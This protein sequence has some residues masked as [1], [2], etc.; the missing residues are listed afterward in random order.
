VTPSL[1][2]IHETVLYGPDLEALTAFYEGALGLRAVSRLGALGVAFRLPDSGI[3]LLFDPVAASA[4]GRDVPAHGTN[5]EGHVAF[6]VGV[7]ALAEWRT[8]L[9]DRDV[10]IESELRWD[11]GG[12]SIYVRDPAGNSVELVEGEIWPD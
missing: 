8:H 2:G 7:G 1:V 4:A 9:G 12:I 10:Q 11:R 3:L 6:L 5:G